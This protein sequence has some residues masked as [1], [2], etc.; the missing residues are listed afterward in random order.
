H[1]KFMRADADS[2]KDVSMGWIRGRFIAGMLVFI[3]PSMICLFT[4]LYP[5]EMHYSEQRWNEVVM[6]EPD[7]PVEQ[8]FFATG[9]RVSKIAFPVAVRSDEGRGVLTVT[10]L[11]ASGN[12]LYSHEDTV[13]SLYD[14]ERVLLKPGVPVEE[15]AAYT[16]RFALTGGR[17]GEPVLGL[18][19]GP[20]DEAY[21]AAE[22]MAGLHHVTMDI[23]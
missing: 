4:T 6:L 14:G 11:D 1:P 19:A 9:S 21:P 20:S 18:V 10:L 3:V 7:V 17:D 5:P 2:M 8:R 13:V 23:R 22:G 15:G 16:V 12:V